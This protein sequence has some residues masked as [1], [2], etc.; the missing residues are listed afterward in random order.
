[1]Q[2]DATRL[3]YALIL[4][5]LA[6]T[7]VGPMTASGQAPSPSLIVSPDTGTY[8]S[9]QVFDIV[10]VFKPGGLGLASGQVTLDDEDVT[11]TIA[12]CA[13]GATVEDGVSARCPGLSRTL[14]VPGIH[15]FTVALTLSDGSS[16]SRTVMWEIL[17][18]GAN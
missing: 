7:L 11:S 2:Y 15:L 13:V 17:D 8:A 3:R 14:L 1:M 10:I 12:A 9:W 16:V 6:L 18:A 5:G 4:V